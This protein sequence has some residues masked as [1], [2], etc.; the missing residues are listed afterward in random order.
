MPTKK[1]KPARAL[2][3]G[4]NPH[5]LPNATPEFSALVRD[6]RLGQTDLSVKAGAIGTSNATKKENLGLFNYAHLKVPFPVDFKGSDIHPHHPK[7]GPP[8]SYFLM[9]RSTD[10]YVSASGMFKAAFPW[11][12][13][14]E[15]KAEKSYLQSLETTSREE[16]AALDLAEDYGLLPWVKALLAPDDVMKNID[17]HDKSITPPPKYIF[18]ANEKTHLPPPSSR[19]ST[20]ARSRGRPRG[21]SP[22]KSEKAASPRKQRATKA[23]KTEDAANSRAAAASL[24]EALI[25]SENT[26]IEEEEEEEEESGT[27]KVELSETTQVNGEVET[28]TTNVKVN[29]PGGMSAQV[30][31][32]EQTEEIIREAKAVVEAARKLEGES[33]QASKKRKADELD[34]DSDEEADRQLQPAKKA[35]LAEEELKKERVKNRALFGVAFTLAIGYVPRAK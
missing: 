14:A 18:T 22:T 30:P 7:H 2:P 11:A 3:D 29:L 17:N 21:S 28:T 6:R 19:A 27:V 25:G 33:Y 1:S 15:E 32:Q 13:Q 10:G 26:A 4:V 31:P 35:R 16:I 8:R 5:I 34:Q 20:P 12:T 24:Q 9:R 23:S